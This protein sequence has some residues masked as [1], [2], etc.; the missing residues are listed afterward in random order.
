MYRVEYIRV[1]GITS[2]KG[3]TDI[4]YCR[5]LHVRIDP[6][7]RGHHRRA[8]RTF[9]TVRTIAT[10][11]TKRIDVGVLRNTCRN[12]CATGRSIARRKARIVR[13]V[14]VVPVLVCLRRCGS[15]A[16]STEVT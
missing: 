10:L 9:T 6:L 11:H 12:P 16:A 3:E 1:A 8:I 15:R 7:D 2:P 5:S 14:P 4:Y 13:P